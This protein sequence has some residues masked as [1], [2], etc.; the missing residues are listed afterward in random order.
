MADSILGKI[1]EA[2]VTAAQGLDLA[3]VNDAS[4]KQLAALTGGTL[5]KDLPSRPCVIFAPFGPEDIPDDGGTNKSDDITYRVACA[6]IDAANQK[7]DAENL[8]DRYLWR[9]LLI[10]HFIHNRV[11]VTLS[12]AALYD[13]TLELQPVVNQEAW[14]RNWFLSSFV[15]K[16]VVRKQ[17]R[18]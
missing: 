17:R 8:D 7:H 1:L 4:I 14:A 16:F 9:E 11:S 15:I 13:Q 12:N 6:I 10:D 5:D 18:A 2:A 3:G